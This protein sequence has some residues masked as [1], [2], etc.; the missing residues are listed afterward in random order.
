MLSVVDQQAAH[1]AEERRLIVFNLLNGV[2]ASEV[3]VAYRRSA[4]E[5]MAVFTFVMSKVRS[6]AHEQ[7]A[8][9]PDCETLDAA[10]RNRLLVLHFMKLLNLAKPPVHRRIVS[11]P[12]EQIIGQSRR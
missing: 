12:A 2:P 3:G 6:Y 5:V 11:L 1:L 8:P 7:F 4:A 9:L 10:I